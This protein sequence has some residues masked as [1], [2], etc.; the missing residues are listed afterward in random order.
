VNGAKVNEER[1]CKEYIKEPQKDGGRWRIL[2]ENR[3]SRS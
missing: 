2:T 1:E 3:L